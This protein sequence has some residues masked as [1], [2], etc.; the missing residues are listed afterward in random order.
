MIVLPILPVRHIVQRELI[1]SSTFVG[2]SPPLPGSHASVPGFLRSAETLPVEG[3]G[4][5]VPPI[6]MATYDTS[7][8]TDT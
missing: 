4:A 7:L 5:Q 1:S 8:D 3:C 6:S 2:G